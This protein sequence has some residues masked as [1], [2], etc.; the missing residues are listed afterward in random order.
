VT[1][2]K[3]AIVVHN[4]NLD[5]LQLDTG[6][7]SHVVAVQI[8]TGTCEFY[9]ISAY[10]QF[11]HPVD[12]YLALLDE[13]INKIKSNNV[14][15]EVIVCADANALSASWYSRTTHERGDKIEDFILANNLVILNQSS[16]FTTFSSH[17]GTSN[18]D[19]TMATAGIAKHKEWHISPN[20]SISDHNVILFKIASARGERRQLRDERLSFDLK[21]ANWDLFGK[22]IETVFN[23]TLKNRLVS[24][25]AEQAVDL[26]TTEL[27]DICRRAI[28]VRRIRGKVVPWWNKELTVLRRKVQVA[29]AQMS[30]ARRLDLVGNL[31]QTIIR[32]KEYRREYVKQLR[33][34]KTLV[35]RK[36]VTDKGNEDPWGLVYKILRNKTRNDFNTFHAIKEGNES[37][38]TW[39]ETAKS[40]INKIP[41][42]DDINNRD[43]KVM[44]EVDNYTNANLEPLI[45]IEETEKALKR[46]KNKKAPGLD[47]IN[48]GIVKKLWHADREVIMITFN[49]CLRGSSFPEWKQGILRPI[50]KNIQKDPALLGS[51][52]P[53]ALLPVMG[54]VF[55]RIIAD[56]I[57][58]L[59]MEQELD[60]DKQFGFKTG[61]SIED[62]LRRIT[63]MSRNSEAKYVAVIFFDIAGYCF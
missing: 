59:Y 26:M 36:F 62:A 61:L 44:H 34:S 37:I 3:S 43:R 49:N 53:I 13:H 22:E 9:I 17:S 58:T 12:P 28:G 50:L 48:P 55:E 31:K 2:S 33:L 39:K 35:W 20:R 40:L 60:N 19:V 18:T 7:S 42:N 1:A 24:L 6:N 47:G 23:P 63:E 45:S 5:V 57:Q 11:S 27:Q 21:R 30:R 56:R 10:F 14:R 15:S 38:L 46:V 25:P 51:Y 54:K 52:R 16:L 29:R 32:H 41:N 8:V 4:P